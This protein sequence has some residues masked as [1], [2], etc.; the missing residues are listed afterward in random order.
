MSVGA[1]DSGSGCSGMNNYIILMM[2]MIIIQVT[3]ETAKVNCRADLKKEQ[4]VEVIMS[5]CSTLTLDYTTQD[6]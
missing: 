1:V 3:S 2:G 5:L 4:V 6:A